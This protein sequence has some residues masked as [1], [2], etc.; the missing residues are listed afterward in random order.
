[1]VVKFSLLFLFILEYTP[2][3]TKGFKMQLYID[4]NSLKSNVLIKILKTFKK[5]DMINDFKIV[6]ENTKVIDD[7]YFY[8]RQEKLIK[9]R[10]DINNGRMP[11]LEE[12]EAEKQIEDFFKNKPNQ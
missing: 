10:E 2:I 11:L 8:E 1:M 6:D 9:L 7:P 3:Y 4:V 12:A 5:T